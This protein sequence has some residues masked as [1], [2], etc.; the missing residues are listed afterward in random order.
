MSPSNTEF[1]LTLTFTRQLPATSRRIFVEPLEN[2]CFVLQFRAKSLIVKGS[3]KETC[4]E[5]MSEDKSV[6]KSIDLMEVVEDDDDDIDEDESAKK[7]VLFDAHFIM[8]ENEPKKKAKVRK[9]KNGVRRKSDDPKQ[10]TDAEQSDTT[11]TSTNTSTATTP[12]TS[13]SNN[14]ASSSNTTSTNNTPKKRGSNS[15]G[16]RRVKGSRISKP[17]N[18]QTGNY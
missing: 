1:P 16:K 3:H 6:F 4:L 8:T 12:T 13:S 11:K 7:K 18:K 14:S 5:K 2:H 17:A 10:L 15:E 9:D